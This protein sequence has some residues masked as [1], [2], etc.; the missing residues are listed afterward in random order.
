[1]GATAQRHVFFTY[2]RVKNARW[3]RSHQQPAVAS[4]RQHQM[5]P[6]ILYQRWLFFVGS[7]VLIFLFVF[8][9][10]VCGLETTAIHLQKEGLSP[11]RLNQILPNHGY[12]KT[13]S[14][15]KTRIFVI[16]TIHKNA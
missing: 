8:I 9:V 13:L 12:C 2:G 5:A 4:I 11:N 16:Q 6:Q 15:Q 7:V 14:L 1:M 3:S 10:V